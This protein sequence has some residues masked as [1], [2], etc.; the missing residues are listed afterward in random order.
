MPPPRTAASPP[1]C[2]TPRR[3]PPAT[4][5]RWRRRPATSPASACTPWPPRRSAAPRAVTRSLTHRQIAERLG[6]S[7]RT[8]DNHVARAYAKLGVTS[9]DELRDVL[10]P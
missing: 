8:V 10:R 6:I 3:S 2:D 5:P 1:T 7:K 4:P 9:R